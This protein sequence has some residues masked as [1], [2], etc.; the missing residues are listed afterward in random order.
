MK[1]LAV[2]AAILVAAAALVIIAYI[3]LEPPPPPPSVAAPPDPIR[4]EA[5]ALTPGDPAAVA[6]GQE[7][8]VEHCAACHGAGLEGQ[9]D[10]RRRLP[11]GR[12]PAPP[13]DETG[14]TWHHPDQ[15]LFQLTRLGPAAIVGDGY[16]SDMP[17][18]QGILTDRQ[19][20]DVLSYIKSSWPPEIQA[21]HDE[22]NRQAQ[23]S[24]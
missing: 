21:R 4:P 20:L 6:R 17:G 11:S 3:A 2:A 7:I 8:Y 23:R 10:W 19:I 1:K 5:V 13:H 18:Y 14:H 22:L 12:L 16:E 15:V 24:H 9:P